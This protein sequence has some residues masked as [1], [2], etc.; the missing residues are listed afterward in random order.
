MLL[1]ENGAWKRCRSVT[2][3]EEGLVPENYIEPI[4][5][6]LLGREAYALRQ[7]WGLEEMQICDEW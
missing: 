5:L 1:D 3:G 2:S 6:L 4:L 7:E